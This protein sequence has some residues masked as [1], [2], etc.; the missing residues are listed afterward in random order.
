L[1]DPANALLEDAAVNLRLSPRACHR[2]LRVARTIADLDAADAISQAHIAEAIALRQPHT[3]HQF[4]QSTSSRD[5]TGR[6][7]R[8]F[9]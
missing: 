6:S 3:R 1:D 9:V 4:D 5:T 8:E 2:V 7:A